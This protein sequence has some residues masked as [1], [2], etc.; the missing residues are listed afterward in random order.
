MGMTSPSHRRGAAVRDAVLDAAA[1]LLATEGLS[2]TRV[3]DVA[4]RAGVHETS[5]YR[6]WGTRDNLILEAV[7]HRLDADVPLPDTGSTRE[8]LTGLLTSLAAF[9]ATPTG[10]AVSRLALDDTAQLGQAR[11]EFWA[12][13]IARVAVVVQRGVDR[14]DLPPGADPEFLL[15]VLGGALNLRI[16]QRGRPTDRDYVSRLVDLVLAGVRTVPPGGSSR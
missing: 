4:V 10:K 1:E 15:E 11:N 12:A 16:L 13:R 6:R 3:A 14:G 9:L 7:L 8:D 2:G 5:I